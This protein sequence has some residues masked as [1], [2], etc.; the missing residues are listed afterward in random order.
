MFRAAL[1]IFQTTSK[2]GVT[3]IFTKVPKK[4]PHGV[5]FDMLFY[6]KL[7]AFCF[8]DQLRLRVVFLTH[9]T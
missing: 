7:P 4:D 1:T 8:L 9:L 2:K 5:R 6:G 3:N